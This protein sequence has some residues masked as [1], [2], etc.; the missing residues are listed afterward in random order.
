M[1]VIIVTIKLIKCKA[2]GWGHHCIVLLNGS[3]KVIAHIPT[4]QVALGNSYSVELVSSGGTRTA[5]RSLGSRASAL[6]PQH[7]RP[8][9]HYEERSGFSGLNL[10]LKSVRMKQ[11][12][13]TRAGN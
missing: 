12:V 7:C 10:G 1:M 8:G 5:R 4:F 13:P 3:C 2:P 6:T 11:R 9:G